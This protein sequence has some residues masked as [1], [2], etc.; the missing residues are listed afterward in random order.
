MLQSETVVLILRL[1]AKC[2]ARKD[3]GGDFGR[4]KSK[5][6]LEVWLE[7]LNEGVALYGKTEIY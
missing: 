3:K 7:K 1:Y 5:R 4:K 2:F 6:D